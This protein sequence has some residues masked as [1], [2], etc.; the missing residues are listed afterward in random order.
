MDQSNLNEKTSKACAT[1]WETHLSEI[2]IGFA[3]YILKTG[4]DAQVENFVK[5]PL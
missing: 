3:S 2:M 5:A 1:P 4:S